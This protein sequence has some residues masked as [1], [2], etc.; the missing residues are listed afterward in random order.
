MRCWKDV[1]KERE[2]RG[3]F[4]V[5]GEV[6]ALEDCTELRIAPWDFPWRIWA[7]QLGYGGTTRIVSKD[8]VLAD[9]RASQ[10]FVQQTW[11]NTL[12]LNSAALPDQRASLFRAADFFKWPKEIQAY[13]KH[14][15][16]AASATHTD[17]RW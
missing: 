14:Y 1:S 4:D 6:K 13:E 3:R 17:R 5:L 8:P 7:Q 16:Q 9:L 10:K 12:Y 15:V 2:I 11:L